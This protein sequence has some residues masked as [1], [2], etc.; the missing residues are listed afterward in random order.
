MCFQHSFARSESNPE[1]HIAISYVSFYLGQFLSLCAYLIF[2]S[3]EQLFC[4]MTI[5][6]VLSHLVSW[7]NSGYV[8]LTRIQ[9]KQ[10]PT[11]PGHCINLTLICFIPHVNFYHLVKVVWCRFLLYNVASA[12]LQLI[13]MFWGNIWDYVNILFLF[14][15][16]H[17][18]VSIDDSSLKQLLLWCLPNS[19][20][21]L[22]IIQIYGTVCCKV[23]PYGFLKCLLF[24]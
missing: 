19:D 8:L 2:K 4:K 12:P 6:L 23:V 11:F 14:P 3:S 22:I 21:Y 24:Q 15:L 1:K 16:I 17:K 5:N 10:C 20:F 18:V 9:Q 7:L 13:R